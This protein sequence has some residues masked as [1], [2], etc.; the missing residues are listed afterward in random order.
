[1]AELNRKQFGLSDAGYLEVSL[2]KRVTPHA[3]NQ[4]V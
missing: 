2:V 4:S 1:M 3:A